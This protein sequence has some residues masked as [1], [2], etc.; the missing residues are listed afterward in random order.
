MSADTHTPGLLARVLALA[1]LPA[2]IAHEL[3]HAIVAL[4]WAA[5]VAVEFDA[6]G[7]A[8]C[9]VTWDGDPPGYAALAAAYAPL[10]VGLPVG[11][12]GLWALATGPL[13]TT[14][15]GW[16]VVAVAGGYWTIFVAHDP[17]DR[18]ETS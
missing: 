7:G 9:H 5:S 3:A 13:P 1:S 17:R 4:P 14:L 10:W 12:V 8:T 6:G 11:L 16:L 2:A 15:R 18:G